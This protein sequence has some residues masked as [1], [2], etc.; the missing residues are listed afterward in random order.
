[1]AKFT[2][3]APGGFSLSPRTRVMWSC[4]ADSPSEAKDKFKAMMRKSMGLSEECPLP[5]RDEFIVVN[6]IVRE[7]TA[8]E[9]DADT[10]RP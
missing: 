8:A 1:M 2:V 3:D 5:F 4:D 6:E 10:V 7:L 9:M